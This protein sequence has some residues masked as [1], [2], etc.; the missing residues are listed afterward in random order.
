MTAVTVRS[1]NHS[2]PRTHAI[3]RITPHCVEGQCT[4]ESLG[5]WFADPA[6]KASSNYGIDKDGRVVLIVDEAN[7]SWCSSSA[8]NDQRAVTIECAS[9]KTDPYAMRGPVY[10]TLVALCADICRR[11]GKTKLLWY[12]NKDYAIAYVPKPDEMLLTVHRWFA[13]KS[14][15]GD[16]LYSRLGDLAAR[17]TALL[18][19]APQDDR[20]FSDV[21]ASA[22]YAQA[23]R[24]AAE[25]GIV[26]GYDDGTFRPDEPITRAQAVSLLHRALAD[27]DK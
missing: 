27:K 8:S 24:W 13:A 17:V 25:S 1:P 2:G 18:S 14:C 15:P 12:P 22:W 6:R 21:P 7:R 5:S 4:A 16:W 9:D 19:P 3:D 11:N 26:S 20:I 10:E 23:V